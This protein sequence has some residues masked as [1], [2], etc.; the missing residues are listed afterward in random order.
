MA[1]QEQPQ[2][3]RTRV[4][5]AAWRL[6]GEREDAGV[7]LLEI[8]EA[9]GVSRQTVYVNFG[10]RA[11][12]LLAMVDHRD[13]T[14]PELARLKRTRE[15][16]PPDEALEPFIRAWFKYVPV[17]FKVARALSCAAV[18]DEA[19]HAAWQS[20][21]ALVQGGLLALMRGLKAQG[22]LSADWT[23]EAAADWSYHQMH[24]DTWQHLVIER[25]WKPA[26]VVQRTVA[27]LTQALLAPGAESLR[28]G[29]RTRRKAARPTGGSGPR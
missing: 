24:I 26:E 21:M 7:S 5:E 8:A 22:R 1:E 20:R 9:A 13:A 12:L 19:A 25:Q 6:I 10:S 14:A 16:L 4:L 28:A 3:A 11:G 23:P 29:G 18:T 17:V 15:E 27:N 2:D